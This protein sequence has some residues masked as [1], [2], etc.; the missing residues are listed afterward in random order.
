M[1]LIFLLSHE[2]AD[3]SQARSGAIVELIPVGETV[4]RKVAHMGLYAVLG[5]LALWAVALFGER[6]G[7]A[8][9]WS[10]LIAA[11][12]AITDEFHQLF[13]PGRSGEFTD[14]LIDAAGVTIGVLI[15]ATVWQRYQKRFLSS[16]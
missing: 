14:I 1:V 4:I 5:A 12:Y 15:A 13:I 2:A 3:G 8:I 10:L 7:R 9:L 11:G 16:P 6:K